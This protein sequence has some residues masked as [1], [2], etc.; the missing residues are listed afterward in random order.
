MSEATNLVA[1]TPKEERFLVVELPSLNGDA[2]LAGKVAVNMMGK[3]ERDGV[4]LVS[5]VSTGADG[6]IMAFAACSDDAISKGLKANEWATSAVVSLQGKGGG[7]PKLAQANAVGLA[8]AP[9]SVP[10][11]VEGAKAY[12]AKFV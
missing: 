10:S 9:S 11:V 2:K 8:D 12:A 1:S 7:K 6:R 3:G 4:L 5:C